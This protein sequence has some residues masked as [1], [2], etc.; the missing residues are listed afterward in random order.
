MTTYKSGLGCHWLGGEAMHLYKVMRGKP[1]DYPG[2]YPTRWRTLGRMCWD[3]ITHPRIDSFAR[4]D[5]RPA[6]HELGLLA[7]GIV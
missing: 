3:F 7:R 6:A 1:A 5:M 2:A 4:D